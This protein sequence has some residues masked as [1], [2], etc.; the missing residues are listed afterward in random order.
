[1][2]DSRPFRSRVCDDSLLLHHLFMFKPWFE[3]Y[4]NKMVYV[5]FS[6]IKTWIFAVSLDQ[7]LHGL[8]CK[9]FFFKISLWTSMLD[10]FFY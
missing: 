10:F 5:F 9:E 3:K 2:Q 4:N 6:K 8:M 7:L 1:M